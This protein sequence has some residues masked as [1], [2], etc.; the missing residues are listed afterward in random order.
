MRDA[1]SERGCVGR[2]RPW[3]PRGY[4]DQG[5]RGLPL[6]VAGMQGVRAAL[7]FS[8]MAGAS[9]DPQPL[10]FSSVSLHCCRLRAAVRLPGRAAEARQCPLREV[11][12]RLR[13]GAAWRRRW[14]QRLRER[15]CIR[16]KSPRISR[17]G[18]QGARERRVAAEAAQAAQEAQV[19]ASSVGYRQTCRL[20]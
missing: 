8:A 6:S 9:R 1:T 4:P 11:A 17:P 3:G 7:V 5:P 14:K 20:L 10:R 15:R 19:P 16:R 13:S 18:L 12:K 2:P